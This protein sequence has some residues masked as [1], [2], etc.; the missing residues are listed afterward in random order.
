V[1]D[2]AAAGVLTSLDS[3]TVAAILWAATE[4]PTGVCIAADRDVDEDEGLSLMGTFLI[5][6]VTGT[7]T[8]IGPGSVAFEVGAWI[9]IEGLG[10]SFISM[11]LWGCWRALLV[12]VGKILEARI[13][14]RDLS[15]RSSSD[16]ELAT[17]TAIILLWLLA[18]EAAA[19]VNWAAVAGNGFFPD[20][21]VGRLV[22]FLMTGTDEVNSGKSK[23]EP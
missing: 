5:F 21:L 2:M 3:L 1:E 11:N 16:D 13:V 20:C 15:S 10:S 22:G 9:L 14:E 18:R 19:E 23:S 17:S 8:L 6:L 4:G 12:P 7:S